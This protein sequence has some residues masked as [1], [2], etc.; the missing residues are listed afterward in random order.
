MGPGIAQWA[1][2]DT[3]IYEIKESSSKADLMSQ[4]D[5]WTIELKI[6]DTRRVI[7]SSDMSYE[8]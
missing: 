8:L 7:S 2:E 3:E 6:T 1:L 5:T 4:M